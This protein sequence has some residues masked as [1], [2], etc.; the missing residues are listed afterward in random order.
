MFENCFYMPKALLFGMPWLAA[1]PVRLFD[2]SLRALAALT[3][4]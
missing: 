4:T 2:V 3:R 1:R